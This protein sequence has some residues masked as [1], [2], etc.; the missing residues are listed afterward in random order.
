MVHNLI[1]SHTLL[2]AS[3]RS[4]VCREVRQERRNITFPVATSALGRL[5]MYL[6]PRL[7]R[8]RGASL[9]APLPP[10]GERLG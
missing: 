1:P 3:Q 10:G 4:R 8:R 7:R 9:T 2:V 6:S 5:T